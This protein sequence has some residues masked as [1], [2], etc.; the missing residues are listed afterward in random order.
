MLRAVYFARKIPRLPVRVT[1]KL[2]KIQF[3]TEP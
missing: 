2:V 1:V 3:P